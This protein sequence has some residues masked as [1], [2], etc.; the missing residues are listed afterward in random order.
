MIFYQDLS[1]PASYAHG[2]LHNIHANT[3]NSVYNEL[4]YNKFLVI[5]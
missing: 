4:T 1:K 2:M 5:Q 3:V